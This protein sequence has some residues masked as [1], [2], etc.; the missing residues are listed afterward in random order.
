MCD[1]KTSWIQRHVASTKS[2]LSISHRIAFANNSSLQIFNLL[3]PSDTN[4]IDGRAA[5][6]C[7]PLLDG[8]K[9]GTPPQM[10]KFRFT[11]G[12][13]YKLRL[14]NVGGDGIQKFSI[15]GHKMMVV[16][17]DFTQIQPYEATV[18]TLA[19]GIDVL[20]YRRAL[21]PKPKV[22]QRSEVIV[23]ATGAPT[24]TYWMRSHI[25]VLCLDLT[26]GPETKAAIY[27]EQADT[28]TEPQSTAWPDQ[29]DWCENVRLSQCY[30]TKLEA[31][32]LP[33]CIDPDEAVLSHGSR[34]A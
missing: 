21:T 17:N 7:S 28:N 1:S 23:E 20:R 4:M 11:A 34:G 30:I 14:M 6:H 15:D 8:A 24:D 3:P 10:P 27:Y 25:S 16:S 18:V 31:D 13:K 12:K 22:G 29:T 33:G 26:W 5:I 32:G 9:C 2:S 19:V